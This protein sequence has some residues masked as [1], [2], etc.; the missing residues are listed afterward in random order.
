MGRPPKPAELK[1]ATGRAPGRD[2]GGRKLPALAA[3]TA[4]PMSTHIPDAPLSLGAEGR[5][6]WERSWSNAITWL[7]SD[8]DWDAIENACH[9]ADDLHTARMKYRA[10][11]EAADGRVLVQLNRAFADA[12][13]AL[14]FDPVSRSRLGVAEVKVVSELDKLIAKRQERAR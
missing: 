5:R 7:S 3:V 11:L 13:S 14:G 4:L 8:S 10:T 6:L 9:I 12:L 2:S 1:R